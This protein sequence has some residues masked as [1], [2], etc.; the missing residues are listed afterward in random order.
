MI[1][2][3]TEKENNFQTI[4]RRWLM[5]T[6]LMC[7]VAVAFHL[8]TGRS[9]GK[10]FWIFEIPFISFLRFIA[11]AQQDYLNEV[12]IDTLTRE[13]VLK[14]YDINVG[15]TEKLLKFEHARIEFKLDKCR[16][17]EPVII[18]FLRGKREVISAYKSKDGFSTETLTCLKDMLENLTI[19]VS[20]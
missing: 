9:L 7:S 6:I 15:Q 8:I 1:V 17:F 11:L 2:F 20:K 19:P 18:Y 14:Y 5:D 10:Y 16:L 4:A 3:K 12:S 13:F